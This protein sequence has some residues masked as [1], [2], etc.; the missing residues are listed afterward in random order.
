MEGKVNEMSFL[1]NSICFFSMLPATDLASETRFWV[2]GFGFFVV[3][4]LFPVLLQNLS[5]L[6]Y[7]S[8]SRFVSLS[9]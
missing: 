3:V 2:L 7:F 6:E 1:F 5:E 8:P 9:Y 4:V